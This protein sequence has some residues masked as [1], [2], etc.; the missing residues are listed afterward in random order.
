MSDA[1]R[2]GLDGLAFVPYV[3]ILGGRPTDQRTPCRTG[4]HDGDGAEQDHDEDDDQD[5]EHDATVERADS[6]TRQVDPGFDLD[7]GADG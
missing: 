5:A 1:R 2:W 6:G 4:T 7:L 3:G